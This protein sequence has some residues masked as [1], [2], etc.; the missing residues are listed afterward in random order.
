L[1]SVTSHA[2]RY[3]II[4][5]F[6]SGK[7]VPLSMF[8]DLINAVALSRF[9]RAHQIFIARGQA[10]IIVTTT[11]T[12]TTTTIIIIIIIIHAR[13]LYNYARGCG[14]LKRRPENGPRRVPRNS[15]RTQI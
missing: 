13:F 1:I 10:V 8:D 9:S 11:M 15:Q 4:N 5:A 2:R 14:G 6:R 7:C 3:D 12:T